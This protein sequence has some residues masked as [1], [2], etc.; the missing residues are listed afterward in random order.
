ME[1][2]FADNQEFEEFAKLFDETDQEIFE[3]VRFKLGTEFQTS[4]D[5]NSMYNKLNFKNGTIEALERTRKMLSVSSAEHIIDTLYILGY[6]NKRI[7]YCLWKLGYINISFRD[8]RKYIEQNRRRLE[9]ETEKFMK[10]LNEKRVSLF[11][12]K[13]EDVLALETRNLKIYMAAIAKLQDALENDPEADVIIYPAKHGRLVKQIETLQA[14]ID[15]MHGITGK[16]DASID[17]NKTVTIEKML[18]ELKDAPPSQ[19]SLTTPLNHFE[20]L[21]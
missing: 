3:N 18:K 4:W 10:E 16:R 7:M 2:D 19:E 14:K 15:K 20:R 17:I 13:Q 21:V 8:Y 12:E 6:A 9:E 5:H 1:P 11:Q